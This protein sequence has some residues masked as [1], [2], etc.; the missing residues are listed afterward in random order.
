[1][2]KENN[3]VTTPAFMCE[4]AVHHIYDGIGNMVQDVLKL[5]KK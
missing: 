2:D 1:M 4:T 5:V 3:I